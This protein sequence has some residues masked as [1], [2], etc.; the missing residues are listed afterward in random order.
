MVLCN[1]KKGWTAVDF[2]HTNIVKCPYLIYNQKYIKKGALFFMNKKYSEEFKLA[3]VKEYL[4][5]NIGIRTIAKKYNLPSKNY[6]TNWIKYFKENGTIPKNASVSHAVKSSAKSTN[7]EKVKT[8]Y[9]KELEKKLERMEAEL[10][11]YKKC[12]EIIKRNKK[13]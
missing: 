2:F 5:G 8:P 11:F 13:K 4:E 9:E 7:D 3:I 10:A 6:I 1:V 12:N